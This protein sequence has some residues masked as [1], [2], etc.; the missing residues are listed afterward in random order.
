[1]RHQRHRERY[2]D[3]DRHL[4]DHLQRVHRRQ[5]FYKDLNLQHQ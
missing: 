5:L 2:R 1:M 4:D 3:L